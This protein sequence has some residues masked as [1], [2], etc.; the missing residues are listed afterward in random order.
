MNNAGFSHSLRAA[1]FLTG[2]LLGASLS[3]TV[4]GA[5][6]DAHN[7]E[8]VVQGLLSRAD[9][10]FSA[11]LTWKEQTGTGIPPNL[12]SDVE[13]KG[14]FSG[15]SWAF[16]CPSTGG[17]ATNHNGKWVGWTK[18]DPG[19]G[20][21]A[22][23]L[24][25]KRPQ[26]IDETFPPAVPSFGGSFWF[27][28]TKEYVSAHRGNAVLKGASEVN[29]IPVVVLEWS[30]PKDAAF[31]AFH[32]VGEQTRNGGILRLFVAPQLGYVLPRVEFAGVGGGVD[33]RFEAS[34]FVEANPGIFFPKKFSCQIY[35]QGKPGVN[36]SYVVTHLEKVNDVI[37]EEDFILHVPHGAQVSDQRSP[38]GSEFYRVGENREPLPKDLG[39][40]IVTPS[41][42][43]GRWARSSTA[44]VIGILVGL[45]LVGLYYRA[46]R[47]ALRNK[48]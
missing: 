40:L 2:C 10:V 19:T 27:Q 39:D 18:G 9:A 13:L 4:K 11:R 8:T 6:N 37:P 36:V 48:E 24:V 5:V 38:V 42:P 1:A 23:Y 43:K 17:S 45:L 20:A 12:S 31:K 15:S 33:N 21:A 44:I 35:N 22:D 30:V 25:I 7:P 46:R 47:R 34:D 41:S 29:G 14:S 16:R 28:S 26:P 32:A 3:P